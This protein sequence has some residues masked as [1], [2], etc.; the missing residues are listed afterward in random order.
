MTSSPTALRLERTYDAP[1]QAVFDAWTDPEVMRR[2]W[3]PG[4]EWDTS[5]AESDLRPGGRVRVGMR[6]PDGDEYGGGGE[7][8][9]IRPPERLAF[10]WIWD[11]DP[12][13]HSSLI[14][15][16]FEEHDGATT[17]VLTHSGL[18]SEDSRE[19]HRDGWHQALE[20]LALKALEA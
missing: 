14:E 10:T 15:L 18:R 8:T 4:R 12:A 11:D 1:A 7:Y 17:L 2:W 3:H 19:G 13:G 20:N 9:E 16:D 6:S 5:L